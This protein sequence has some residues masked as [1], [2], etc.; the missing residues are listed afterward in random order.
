M[1]KERLLDHF[2]LKKI[3]GKISDVQADILD[4]R[5]V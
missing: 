2:E 5:T 4:F 3:L 1:L